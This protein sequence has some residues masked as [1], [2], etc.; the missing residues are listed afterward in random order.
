MGIGLWGSSLKA[1]SAKAL[2]DHLQKAIKNFEEE[3]Q[4]LQL[5]CTHV[6]HNGASAVKHGVCSA[7][8]KVSN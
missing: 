6:Y 2:R 7:C 5:H 8:G 3:L 4:H 1:E